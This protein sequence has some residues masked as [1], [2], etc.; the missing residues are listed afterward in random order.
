MVNNDEQDK[1]S[2]SKKHRLEI[3][4]NIINAEWDIMSNGKKVDWIHRQNVDVKVNSEQDKRSTG[5]CMYVSVCG[6]Y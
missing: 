6:L 5:I 4:L 3:M 2:N 1:T